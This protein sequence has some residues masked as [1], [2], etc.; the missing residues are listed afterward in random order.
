MEQLGKLNSRRKAR[1][2]FEMSGTD[3]PVTRRHIPE[4]RIPLPIRRENL[5]ANFRSTG[6]GLK[7]QNLLQQ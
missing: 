3:Y 5:T 4:E 1:R 2:Y 6:G 7:R